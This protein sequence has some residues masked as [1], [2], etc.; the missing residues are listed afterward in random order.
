MKNFVLKTISSKRNLY[1]M[2]SLHSSIS[3]SFSLK[4]EMIETEILKS[5]SSISKKFNISPSN[6]EPVY[7]SIPDSS[8]S[9]DYIKNKYFDTKST[10]EID[11]I[12]KVLFRE[13]VL[14]LPKEKEYENLVLFIKNCKK[15]NY[16]DYLK[17]VKFFRN[18]EIR[19][20][21]LNTSLL[22]TL[23][24]KSSPFSLNKEFE[25]KIQVQNLYKL[26]KGEKGEKIDSITEK[27]FD[28][29]KYNY[30]NFLAETSTF[31]KL[32]KS[33]KIEAK[34]KKVLEEFKKG[35]NL[36]ENDEVGIRDEVWKNHYVEYLKKM[37]K[38]ERKESLGLSR[39]EEPYFNDTIEKSK[40]RIFDETSGD[41]SKHNNVKSFVD[42]SEQAEAEA[43]A[44]KKGNSAASQ[45]TQSNRMNNADGVHFANFATYLND[46]TSEPF[47]FY[48]K[49]DYPIEEFFDETINLPDKDLV[50]ATLAPEGEMSP[51]PPKIADWLER[52]YADSH[53]WHLFTSVV[54]QKLYV[55]QQKAGLIRT[56]AELQ[57]I[58]W[59]AP[60]F[61][62]MSFS[63]IPLPP[64]IIDYYNLLP[65]WARDHPTMKTVIRG[66]EYHQ[67]WTSYREK[68]MAVNWTLQVLIGKDKT[69]NE[70][71]AMSYQADPE[72]LTMENLPALLEHDEEETRNILQ[73]PEDE[74]TDDEEMEIISTAEDVRAIEKEEEEERKKKKREE[75]RAKRAAEE[76]KQA[77]AEN[78]NK[79]D[80]EKKKKEEA[81][82]KKKEEAAPEEEEAEETDKQE[83]RTEAKTEDKEL[84][85]RMFTPTNR[86][87][88]SFDKEEETL[89]I[90]DNL[91]DKMRG[92]K[93]T[94]DTEENSE[95]I[96]ESEYKKVYGMK[97]LSQEDETLSFADELEAFRRQNKEQKSVVENKKEKIIAI[98]RD[99]RGTNNLKT[100]DEKVKIIKRNLD[101]VTDKKYI[102]ELRNIK[103]V[104]KKK[105]NEMEDKSH[106]T[107]DVILYPLSLLNSNEF[108]EAEREIIAK[109]FNEFITDIPD[110]VRDANIIPLDQKKD[111]QGN[112]VSETNDDEIMSKISLFE[113]E[114]KDAGE[115]FDID[116]DYKE[117]LKDEDTS[118]DVS[119]DLGLQDAYYKPKADLDYKLRSEDPIPF[120]FYLNEDG[121]W[122]NYIAFHRKR[123]NPGQF[124]HK[125][126]NPYMKNIKK[127]ENI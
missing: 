16:P 38:N 25:A 99:L 114:S 95:N 70:L 83:A 79:E 17:D 55:D 42:A 33:R 107:A 88:R 121:F 23:S 53:F 3:K 117:S 41:F 127:N 80:A 54:H 62:M 61:T 108:S 101:E 118:V 77:A 8:I 104:E 102:N 39:F 1:K 14:N 84:E 51:I 72:E 30:M 21:M 100:F 69:Y 75:G 34:N 28:L 78:K 5:F 10:K 113:T 18:K 24:Q 46:G 2:A 92:K 110:V 60:N 120:E 52:C 116:A 47:P 98:L 119:E 86:S 64:S 106:L 126:F 44:K 35:D 59:D 112:K 96:D 57:K 115:G 27:E 19:N 81:D 43:E 6:K 90:Y 73:H 97:K 122:N 63:D 125:P 26:R 109:H 56:M 40:E 22:E 48:G 124:V 105:E 20:F 36:I 37:K 13:E 91:Y 7:E 94:E 45:S 15:Y 9:M 32:T 68:V 89:N 29:E 58:N 11:Q 67:P 93:K 85:D 71:L 4:A 76:A 65:K 49:D 12:I 31:E 50:F 87:K 82:K 66:L 103:V 74:A 123:I 111:A